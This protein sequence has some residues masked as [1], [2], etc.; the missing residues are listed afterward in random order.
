V[1][2]TQVKDAHPLLERV[3]TCGPSPEAVEASAARLDQLL[4]SAAFPD[5][6]R[7][8]AE[9]DWLH[10]TSQSSQPREQ[11]PIHVGTLGEQWQKIGLRPR[12]DSEQEQ[13]KQFARLLR[14]YPQILEPAL[15]ELLAGRLG[16]LL[17]CFL[18][19]GTNGD[20]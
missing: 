20:R 1:K 5:R 7:R 13:A 6:Q 12:P 11:S 18:N 8:R 19:P 2:V 9:F 16:R 3:A 10:K 15:A 17:V 14:R 4:P